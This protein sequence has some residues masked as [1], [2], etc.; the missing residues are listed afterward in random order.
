MKPLVT[1]CIPTYNS[2]AYIEDTLRSLTKQTYENIEIIIG[3]NASD[4]NTKQLVEDYRLNHDSRVIYY[5]NDVNI[6]YAGNCNKLVS[7][8]R[9]DFISI[10]HSDD[11][12]SDEIVRKQVDYLIRNKEVAGCFT[13]YMTIDSN[14]NEKKNRHLKLFD[15]FKKKEIKFNYL[16]AVNS[17]VESGCNPFFCP[18]SMLRKSAYDLSGGYDEK[19]KY[20]EDQDLWIRIL[21]KNNL[22][23]INEKLVKYRIH[24]QQGSA[25]YTDTSRVSDSPMIIHISEHL[26]SK[27]GLETYEKK[28]KIK[29]D[30]LKA[31]DALRFAFY[32]VKKEE[33]GTYESYKTLIF[34]SKD[35]YIFG[36]KDTRYLR[37]AIFQ[38]LPVFVS[39][40]ILK[41]LSFSTPFLKA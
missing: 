16:E 34:R 39:Y 3:D 5:K 8:A 22:S 31:A 35:N 40:P 18:S 2:A 21:E 41:L 12:Y 33:G 24:P 10:Y 30:R 1:I 29:I 6:G 7:L 17:I 23:V 37:F 11:I 28:Y 14:G 32:I 9:G 38:L 20:I 27:Y 4:D 15:I 36:F 25:I 13:N 26:I 19:I